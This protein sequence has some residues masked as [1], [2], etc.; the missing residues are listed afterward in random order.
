MFKVIVQ[1]DKADHYLTTEGTFA[2]VADC[3]PSGD[4]I[5]LHEA[6]EFATMEGAVAAYYAT[7]TPHP[8]MVLNTLSR[9]KHV[10]A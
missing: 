7:N 9:F 4:E 6:R 8:G 10:I 2:P 5:A 1:I 3:H